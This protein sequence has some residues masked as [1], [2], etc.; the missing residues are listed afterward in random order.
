M[1]TLK[2]IYQYNLPEFADF[3]PE[4]AEELGLQQKTP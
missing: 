2:V 3:R 1:A 4:A